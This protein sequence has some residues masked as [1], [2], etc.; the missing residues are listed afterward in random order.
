V[1]VTAST[2][3]VSAERWSRTDL[4]DRAAVLI[5]F[6]V[7]ALAAL[8]FRDYGLGWDDYTHAQYGELLLALYRSGFTDDRALHF[9]NLEM[10]GGGFDMAAALLAKI[11]PIG[12]F[13]AR[14]LAGAIVG[15]IGLVATWR[16]GRRVGGPLCGLIALVLLGS[17]PLYDGH[18]FMN[19][20]D[21]P[22][23]TAMAILLLG[24]VRIFEEYP[25][26]S[27]ASSA[28]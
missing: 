18:M 3:A 10:Y 27:L 22:F 17:C 4:C 7:A 1:T 12:L 2:A 16:I 26:P 24:L 25:R 20:K 13:E 6:I 14:R 21:A 5:L 28:L 8:V 23:A 11:I 9:V 19:P 15:L